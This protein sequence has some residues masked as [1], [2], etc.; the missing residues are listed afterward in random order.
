MLRRMCL[1]AVCRRWW[2][3]QRKDRK[4]QRRD[5]LNRTRPRAP[6]HHAGNYHLC[7]CNSDHLRDRADCPVVVTWRCRKFLH[8]GSAPLGGT[9]H[10]NN[11]P[12]S[13]T[14]QDATCLRAARAS[15]SGAFGRKTLSE[16]FT[17]RA[18]TVYASNQ[19]LAER[20]GNKAIHPVSPTG[21]VYAL[22]A[23]SIV[24]GETCRL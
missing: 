23:F 12:Y 10:C 24:N 19:G 1:A 6:L 21:T 4:G 8:H 2:R 15:F 17:F 13:N 3:K 14:C 16:N 22:A 5:E 9:T 11:Y 7:R 20:C 18:V